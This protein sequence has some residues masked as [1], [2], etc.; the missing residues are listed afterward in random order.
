MSLSNEMPVKCLECAKSAPAVIHAECMFCQEL[1]F[2]EEIL[3]HLNRCIQNPAD[4]Q[5]HA[6]RP[7]LKLVSASGARVADSDEVS[8]GPVH[9]E[10]S[11]S[12]LQI[13]YIS[14]WNR[15]VSF[16]WRQ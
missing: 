11:P 1:E 8:N 10:F 7:K 3:C 13:I 12:L 5:C 4:F 14:W 15:M 6:F 2:R 16:L 9:R